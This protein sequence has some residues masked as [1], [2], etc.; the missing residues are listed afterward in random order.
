MKKK[1]FACLLAALMLLSVVACA[2]PA[3]TEPVVEATK[4]PVVTA[5]P[6]KEPTA[7]PTA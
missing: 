2:K 3:T 5:A 4:E 1:V 6:T 7:A